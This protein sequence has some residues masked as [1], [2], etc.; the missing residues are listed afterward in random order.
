MERLNSGQVMIESLGKRVAT[1]ALH[2]EF[3][4]DG[5]LFMGSREIWSQC[6]ACTRQREEEERCAAAQQVAQRKA[7]KILD[8]T[9]RAAIPPRFVGM[10]FKNFVVETDSQKTALQ[11]AADFAERF[12]DMFTNGFG[13]VFSG[14]P[15]TGKTHLSAAILQA[16]M[17]KHCGLYVTALGLVRMVRSTWR[18]DAEQTEEDVIAFLAGLPLLVID[19]IGVQYGTDG[20][21]TILF[22]VLDRRYCDMKPSILLTNQN[23]QGF[24]DYVGDRVYDRLTQ[25]ARWVPCDWASYR[26]KA[27]KDRT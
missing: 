18:K 3:S 8:M 2:G 17:P 13:L 5:T 7:M 20:E 15:G 22:E 11:I 10:S 23:K 12:E 4:A 16:I 26:P 27:R 14:P 21:Q 25:I 6:P 9:K 19:E 1:C 24:K